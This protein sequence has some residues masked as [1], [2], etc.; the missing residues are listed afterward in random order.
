MIGVFADPYPDEIDYSVYARTIEVL[1]FPTVYQG[2]QGIFGNR[3]IRP[4]VGLQSGLD[5]LIS[6]LPYGANYSLEDLTNGHS[7]LPLYK[8]FY[9]IKQIVH[10]IN[11][12]RKGELTG[13]ANLATSDIY[14]IPS[15][16]QLNYCPMC[17]EEDRLLYGEAYWHRIHQIDGVHI[18]TK[19]KC[20]LEGSNIELQAMRSF[21]TADDAIE[22]VKPQFLDL[23]EQVHHHHLH[24]SLNIEWLLSNTIEHDG[25]LLQQRY[26]KLLFQHEF[27]T[28]TG[29]IRTKQLVQAF[30]HFYGKEFLRL[31]GC[32][33]IGQLKR[34][35]LTRLLERN[36]TQNPH[37]VRHLLLI[38]MLGLSCKEF[39][40][41]APEIKPFGNGPW[42]CLCPAVCKYR[43]QYVIDELYLGISR[44][45]Q[46]R[47]RG[48]FRCSHCGYTYSRI[49][50]DKTLG[51]E[52][53][54]KTLNYGHAW[55]A[56]LQ[57]LWYDEDINFNTKATILGVGVDTLKR[58]AKRLGLINDSTILTADSFDVAQIDELKEKWLSILESNQDKGVAE[59]IESYGQIYWELYQSCIDWLLEHSP[60]K[61]YA[62]LYQQKDWDLIDKLLHP[63][64]HGIA[65]KILR[66]ANPPK[67][68]TKNAIGKEL[69]WADGAIHKDLSKIP[70]TKEAIDKVVETHE[71]FAVRRINL[72]EAEF[73]QEKHLPSEAEFIKQ[74]GISQ[75]MQT[76]LVM[77]HLKT[78]IKELKQ[79]LGV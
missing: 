11:G 5:F 42:L 51:N 38:N 58:Q 1:G 20:W 4:V 21:V 31:L 33:F 8:P 30:D 36:S 46:R 69:G 22:L 35:W 60:D 26:R 2:I 37:P 55:D 19:H 25:E 76:F 29:S 13:L 16:K 56:K 47:P 68:I 62:S 39:F 66:S 12:M 73:L 45:L 63:K 77:S 43:N 6:E 34:N 71:Q 61:R 7:I 75:S 79:N 41:L 78:K 74:A 53:S 32:G 65:E 52:Y 70:R 57:E 59:L 9:P 28:Y 40:S 27:A 24:L 14:G 64:V 10:V 3:A 67:R 54:G 49:G 15:H 17:V 48:I 23:D 50:P 18:C 44:Q 72:C